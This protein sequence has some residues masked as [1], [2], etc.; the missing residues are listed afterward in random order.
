[1]TAA[2]AGEVHRD[3]GH[4]ALIE[5]SRREHA[6]RLAGDLVERAE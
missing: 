2:I 1:M 6:E 5:P 4:A 3:L